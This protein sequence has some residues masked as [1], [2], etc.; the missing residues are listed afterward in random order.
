MSYQTTT[1]TLPCQWN[2]LALK[3]ICL[4][5]TS[6]PLAARA[7]AMVHT[8]MYNAWANY[9]DC[10]RSTTTFGRLR[11]PA[12]E[13]TEANWQKAYS[14][15]AF[16]IL[17]KLFC[18]PLPLGEK[19]MFKDK[20]SELSYD[21]ED[22]NLADLSKPECVGNLSAQMILELFEG[23]GSN[24]N[25]NFH[26][27]PYSDYL[28]YKPENVPLSIVP[29][30]PTETKDV[31]RWQPLTTNGATQTFLLPHW[32][33]V[34]PFAL[35][36]PWRFRPEAPSKWPSDKF[37]TELEEIISLSANLTDEHKMIA[38][39]WMAGVGSVTPP[40]MWMEVA[41][42][43]SQRDSHKDWQDV[44]L[45]FALGNAAH[46]SAVAAWDAKYA[47]DFVRPITA[48]RNLKKGQSIC[49]WAGVCQ[50]PAAQI[51]DGALWQT[52]IPTPPFA[53]YV[54]GH[55]T[56]SAA[57]AYILQCFTGSN[58]YD[59]SVEFEPCSSKIE[60]AC[61]PKEKVTLCWA[62]F[63]EAADQAGMSRR[64]G[65]IHFSEGD[66]EGRKLGKNVADCVWRK[67]LDFYNGKKTR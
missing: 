31:N 50:E 61:T 56:F 2:E 36:S 25:G 9:D 27:P 37:K 4:T 6:P 46:D 49:A 14:Y 64:Y 13:R 44:M 62:T 20:M 23:D 33:L 17:Q 52:Y 18:T 48:V 45:F 32:G 42:L 21:P 40:G 29:P 3:A 43:I 10:A 53:E 11:R 1:P 7:L 26:E 35:P 8:A 41:Q 47:Y 16:Q 63:T 24:D 58:R 66:L 30:K 39:Y 57:A 67:T 54:S 34:R 12:A 5:K 51:M 22:D 55:S 65:G 60:P 19:D 15:A 38:E 59:G 28:G